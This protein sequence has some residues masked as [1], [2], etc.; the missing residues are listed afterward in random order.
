MM[1]TNVMNAIDQLDTDA[2]INTVSK[3]DR[4]TRNFQ[5]ELDAW[6]QQNRIEPYNHWLEGGTIPVA[7]VSKSF[8]AAF[9]QIDNLWDL[10][11]YLRTL[12][13][14]PFLHLSRMIAETIS[15]ECASKLA[16]QQSAKSFA[17][18][19][20]TSADLGF[21]SYLF[22]ALLEEVRQRK[23]FGIAL[24]R[25]QYIEFTLAELQAKL[26]AFE[27]YWELIA[28]N[29]DQAVAQEPMNYLSRDL[30]E[31]LADNY[32]QFSGGRGYMKGHPAEFAF[33]EVFII[34]V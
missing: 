32:L 14:W 31:A 25:N 5:L 30:L 2:E 20:K 18:L 16:V 27:A 33:N 4:P 17:L 15:A 19:M 6:L 1:N 24:V 21:A 11:N 3:I 34:G 29:G 9:A 7:N 8:V 13:Q 22:N 26:L 23:T 12:A 28:E 10:P